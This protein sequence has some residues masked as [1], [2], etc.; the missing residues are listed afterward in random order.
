MNIYKEKQVNTMKKL[1]YVV[2]YKFNKNIYKKTNLLM[3]VLKFELAEKIHCGQQRTNPINRKIIYYV[4]N[5]N[6]LPI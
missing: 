2:K 4:S 3:Y 5:Q 6:S 1:P